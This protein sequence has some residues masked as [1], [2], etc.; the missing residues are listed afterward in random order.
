M[1]T[2]LPVASLLLR[3]GLAA[4]MLSA[5]ADRFGLWA[6]KISTWGTWN[7]F[8]EYTASVN[9]FAPVGLIPFLAQSATVLEIVL[10]VLLIV[11]YKTRWAALGTAILTLA[12]ALAMSLSFGI[13]APLDYSVWV[14]CSAA[15]L[16]A[17]IPNYKWSIDE[18]LQ[19][20][21]TP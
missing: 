16:L 19:K 17:C 18:L 3:L 4:T 15:F 7:N 14:D 1:G 10:G 12:F 11:G 2:K 5:V 6:A 9:S 21:S 13:K 20:T 8:L